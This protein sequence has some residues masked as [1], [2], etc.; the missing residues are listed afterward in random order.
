[1]PDISDLIA[2]AVPREQAV[3]VCLDGAGAAR[4]AELEDEAAALEG[5]QPASL[6]D[7]DPRAELR[8]LIEQARTALAGATVEFRFRALGHRAFSALMAA[9]PPAPDR[10]ELLYG[11]TFLPALLAACS[12]SPTLSPGQVDQLLERVNYGTA[13]ELFAAAVAVNEEPSPI[14]F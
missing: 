13:A 2:A 3:R 6:G 10:P 1:M 7:A 14:P 12:T 5:W 4:L 8:P 9:H 11:D